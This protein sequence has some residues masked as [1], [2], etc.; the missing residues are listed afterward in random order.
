MTTK[1]II[2]YT[3]DNFDDYNNVMYRRK[4]S[5]SFLPIVIGSIFVSVR[6]ESPLQSR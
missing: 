4:K 6:D 5:R 3:D 2:I 1:L